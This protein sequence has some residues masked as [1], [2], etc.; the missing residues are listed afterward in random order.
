MTISGIQRDSLGLMAMQPSPHASRAGS[1]PPGETQR[2]S[3]LLLADEKIVTTVNSWPIPMPEQACAYVPRP[4]IET[5]KETA[6][7]ILRAARAIPRE[8]AEKASAYED[9]MHP[10]Q[11]SLDKNV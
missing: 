9:Q 5:I 2:Q 3:L 8:S 1:V 10:R 6:A 4:G 11:P 7:E